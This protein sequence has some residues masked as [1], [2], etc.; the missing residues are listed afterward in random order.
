MA[1]SV[2]LGALLVAGFWL[3]GERERTERLRATAEGV[4]EHLSAASFARGS[5][6]WNEARLAAARARVQLESG[7]GNAELAALVAAEELAIDRDFEAEQERL[8]RLSR[9]ERFAR[10]VEAIRAR[11][12]RT[13]VAKLASYAQLMA[14]FGVDMSASPDRIV[15]AIRASGLAHEMAATLVDWARL[16]RIIDPDE[17][18]EVSR[19]LRLA[20]AVDDDPGRSALRRAILAGDREEILRIAREEPESPLDP[21]TV[22]V[23]ADELWFHCERDA[24]MSLLKRT[25]L[26]HPN[27]FHLHVKLAARHMNLKDSPG[28]IGHLKAALA[29]EPHNS[30]VA[31]S[32]GLN[33]MR[34]GEV[35]RAVAACERAV[36]ANP[37]DPYAHHYLGVTLDERGDLTDAIPSFRKAV[38]LEPSYTFAVR[39][40]AYA[41]HRAGEHAESLDLYLRSTELE[42]DDPTVLNNAAWRLATSPDAS[43]RDHPRALRLAQRAIDLHED[44]ADY[45]STYAACL[46]YNG[47]LEEAIAAGERAIALSAGPRARPRRGSS[48]WRWPTP[49][50]ETARR[51]WSGYEQGAE[52][53]SRDAGSSS[54]LPRLLD[55]APGGRRA[56]GAA[57]SDSRGELVEKPREHTP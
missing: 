7:I 38:E 15:D 39:R 13:S 40:L 36:A 25:E 10:A 34:V 52:L 19:L 17:T 50:S 28:A 20:L 1:A 47:R 57:P 18:A 2:V 24:A 8:E 4:S 33:Y 30:W 29:R 44:D 12:T 53:V 41:L 26:R 23:L 5:G 32:L 49:S 22:I 54:Q 35:E 56:V 45:A 3:R 51:R 14:E 16:Q 21:M 46:Y 11:V 55:E 31:A 43:L 27:D 48:S 37:T 6:S 42:P 9:R